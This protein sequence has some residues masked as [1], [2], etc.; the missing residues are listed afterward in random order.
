[1]KIVPQ[2]EFVE[3]RTSS[4][5]ATAG[6][7][8]IA[9]LVAMSIG[10]GLAQDAVRNYEVV[11]DTIAAAL[12]DWPGDPVA[13]RAVVANRQIGLCLLCHSGPFPEERF[14][15]DLAPDLRGVGKRSTP[16]QLRLRL[17]DSTLIKPDTIMPPFHRTAD[18]A[19]VTPALRGKP[20]LSA[21]QIEDVLAYLMTLR[22][23][24]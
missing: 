21:Q 14:Q 15:G 18:L 8:G 3:G 2:P 12:T 1:M 23:D 11:G 22:D 24:P 20:I 9:V 19:R 7:F 6:K 10:L 5:P 4:I 16:G 17:V 13:G